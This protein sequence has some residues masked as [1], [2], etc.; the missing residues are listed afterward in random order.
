MS[1]SPIRLRCDRS[2]GPAQLAIDRFELLLEHGADINQPNGE[3]NTPLHCGFY[4]K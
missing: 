2:I 4:G 3:G 1:A